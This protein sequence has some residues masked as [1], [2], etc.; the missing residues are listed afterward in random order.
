MNVWE[1]EGYLKKPQ[2]QKL[3]QHHN[4]LLNLEQKN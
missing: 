4:E 3:E 1:P 2:E